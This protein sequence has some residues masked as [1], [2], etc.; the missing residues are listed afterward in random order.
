[1]MQV[2]CIKRPLNKDSE[3]IMRFLRN[4]DLLLFN[5]NYHDHYLNIRLLPGNFCF[6]GLYY[7]LFTYVLLYLLYSCSTIIKAL[8]NVIHFNS[9]FSS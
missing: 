1:M 2:L 7:H 3:P 4:K 5:S 6:F 8:V 9:I